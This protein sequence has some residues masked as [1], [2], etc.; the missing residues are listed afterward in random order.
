MWKWY[1][2]LGLP[3]KGISYFNEHVLETFYNSTYFKPFAIPPKAFLVY[4]K[5]NGY[6][7]VITSAKI[8][9]YN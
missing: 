1:W 3:I 7:F 6:I 5:G 2:Y 4:N 9:N 8:S